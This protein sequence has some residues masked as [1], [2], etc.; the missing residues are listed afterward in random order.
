M[1]TRRRTNSKAQ[2]AKKVFARSVLYAACLSMIATL[3][4]AIAASPGSRSRPLGRVRLASTSS[5]LIVKVGYVDISNG[6][7]SVTPTNPWY[8]GVSYFNC[9]DG[10]AGKCASPS[11]VTDAGAILLSN[12]TNSTITVSGVSVVVQTFDNRASQDWTPVLDD[13][14]SWGTENL[15]PANVPPGWSQFGYQGNIWGVSASNTISIGAKSD[16]I[17]TGSSAMSSAGAAFDVSDTSDGNI[18]SEWHLP[19][20]I[21]TVAIT[22]GS[23]TTNYYDPTGKIAGGASNGDLCSPYQNEGSNWAVA[24]TTPPPVGG[25]ISRAGLYGGCNGLMACSAGTMPVHHNTKHPVDTASGDL[26]VSVPGFSVPALGHNLDFGLSYDA[27]QIQQQI[28]AGTDVDNDGDASNDTD[29]DGDG[30]YAGPFGWGWSMTNAPVLAVPGTHSSGG[31]IAIQGNG[32]QTDFVPSIIKSTGSVGC[33]DSSVYVMT[34]TNSTFCALPRVTGGTLSY[35]KSYGTYVLSEKGG[36]LKFTFNMSGNLIQESTSREPGQYL[37]VAQDVSPGTGGCPS[38]TTYTW[39]AFCTTYTAKSPSVTSMAIG[40]DGDGIVQGVFEP[41][42][43]GVPP[44]GEW[45]FSYSQQINLASVSDPK[46]NTTSFTYDTGNTIPSLQHDLCS[47]TSPGVTVPTSC[48]TAGYNTLPTAC[49]TGTACYTYAMP[50]GNTTGWSSANRID[51]TSSSPIALNSVS[52]PS[53]NDCVAVDA[54]GNAL[55]YNG[56]F[57]SNATQID[58]T[59]SLTSVSCA[60]TSFCVAVDAKGNAVVYNGTSWKVSAT[61]DSNSLNSV[62]CTSTSSCVAV[63]AAGN[64]VTWNGTSWTVSATGD[65]NSLNSVSCTSTS[66]CTAVDAKGYAVTYDGSSWST[67]TQIDKTNSLNSISCTDETFCAAVDNVGN[68]LAHN[69]TQGTSN[70]IDNGVSINSIS[71]PEATFCVAADSA[72][73]VFYYNSTAKVAQYTDP[74]GNVTKFTYIGNRNSALGGWDSVTKANGDVSEYIYVYGELISK[75]SYGSNTQIGSQ[76]NTNPATTGYARDPGTLLATS[77]T[78]PDGNTTTYVYDTS[79]NLCWSAPYS[80]S[81]PTCGSP[82]AAITNPPAGPTVYTYNSFDEVTSS[83]DPMGNVTTNAYDTN[84]NLCWSAPYVVSSPTCGSPPAPITNPQA[85]PTVYTYNSVGKLAMVTDPIGN[86]TTYAYDSNGNLCWSFPG[87]YSNDPDNDGDGLSTGT[88]SDGDGLSCTSPPAATTNPPAGPTVYTYNSLG[89][90]TTVTDPMGNVTTYAYNSIGE[91]C[92]SLPS[93]VSSPTCNPS[94]AS[95]TVY[96]YDANGNRIESTDP[97]GYSTSYAYNAK[98]EL[99]WKAPVAVSSP[100]CA[101]PPA[102]ATVYTYD[103]LGNRTQVKNPTGGMPVSEQ[104]NSLTAISCLA[105]Q[106][107]CLAVDNHGNWLAYTGAGWSTPQLI[108]GTSSDPIALTSVSCASTTLCAAVDSSGN[109]LTYN[110]TS[111]SKAALIDPGHSLTSV[112][113]TSSTFCVAVDSSG[114][115]SSYT[116]SGWSKPQ[117]IDSGY[118]VYSLT[119]VSCTS[120]TF[121]VAVDNAGNAFTWNGTN[122]TSPASIDD[123]DQV[124]SVSCVSSTF[125]AAVDSAGNALTYNGTSWSAPQLIDNYPLGAVSCASSTLCVAVDSATNAIV[126]N[127]STWTSATTTYAYND[128]ADPS[129]VTSVTT[130]SNATTNVYDPSGDLIEQ[131]KPG[132][133]ISYGYDSLHRVCWKDAATTSVSGTCASPPSGAITYVYNADSAVTQ[134]TDASGTT[135]YFYDSLG[136]VTSV[137]DGN[138][139]VV[140]YGYNAASEVVCIGYPLGPGAGSGNCNNTPSTSNWVVTRTYDSLARMTSV[141]DWL[142]NTTTFSYN[143]DSKVTSISYPP[144]TFTNVSLG[145]DSQSRLTSE[146][147]NYVSSFADQD[148]DGDSASNNTDSDSSADTTVSSVSYSYNADSLRISGT[149][150]SSTGNAWAYSS[151]SRDFMTQGTSGTYA[152][153]QDADGDSATSDT[154]KDSN[155]IFSVDANTGLPSYSSTSAT[156]TSYAYNASQQPCWSSSPAESLGSGS[157]PSCSSVPTA[158]TTYA[159]D[160]LGQLSQV[161][162]L[163]GTS[164]A[165]ASYSYDPYGNLTCATIANTSGFNCSNNES[166]SYTSTYTYNA[167]G[168]RMSASTPLGSQIFAYDSVTGSVPRIINDSANAYIYG[169]SVFGAGQAPIEQINLS[170]DTPSWL[171]SSQMGLRDIIGS[172]G[173]S[174]MDLLASYNYSSWGTRTTAS[175]TATS[176]F[177]FAGGYTD[178]TGLVYFVHRYYDPMLREFISVDPAVATTGTP[179]A[180]AGNNPVNGADPSGLMCWQ[181]LEFGITSSSRQC[182]SSGYAKTG[183]FVATHKVLDGIVLGAIGVATGGAGFLVEGTVATLALGVA[184]VATGSVAAYLDYGPC[185]RGDTAAC[186]GASLGGLGALLGGGALLGPILGVSEESVAGAIMLGLLP[187]ASA[188]FGTAAFTLDLVMWLANMG[189]VCGS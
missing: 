45:T 138:N 54:A 78:G 103:A 76:Q 151:N 114:Y 5:G 181:A 77:K 99:C 87:R 71:C 146:A 43:G 142:G 106:N 95:A 66:S 48:P 130:G 64:A 182:W 94:P 168:L 9:G 35:Y 68:A 89:K 185:T 93:K 24:T 122:W 18:C 20:I 84:G 40:Y 13:T 152:Y 148:A 33:P 50:F 159:Y 17:L 150:N 189:S 123:S 26:H 172:S 58:G 164:R 31:V 81:S 59:N 157:V 127:G 140:S 171:I 21:G 100:A 155:G 37:A 75:T 42:S 118:S 80:V 139:Q 121:C 145:Y 15:G 156:T 10:N 51:G 107:G 154:G 163:Q 183:H 128:A 32:A 108:D 133:I 105:A 162:S 88:G 74:M 2:S 46:G 120:S 27:M 82:P 41:P 147:V 22:V 101:S 179:Y 132:S 65:S 67:A 69:G 169:P 38:S 187:G 160:T 56:S 117:L 184:A 28:S 98:N 72:G 186:V 102:S 136:R 173:T 126:F 44:G 134:M 175:G 49:P 1:R 73:N 30:N 188:I 8:G 16:A 7:K 119:S 6:G 3:L 11:S 96:T 116:S 143:A 113:C 174:S 158:A 125:C 153:D 55:Q 4:I 83:K 57:W 53:R 170:S 79:G 23:K 110:G 112:S 34:S 86:V 29:K 12:P 19:I 124:T 176:P 129:L 92:W 63:D 47:K 70:S 178:Q 137:T 180:Y 90:P 97:M 177:G 161:S 91:L 61:G 25:P 141:T 167:D 115:W 144:N 149:M 60:G 165:N 135:S 39:L 85:G 52:C 104:A 62:S 14:P 109:A 131:T 111:W 36:L 166:S